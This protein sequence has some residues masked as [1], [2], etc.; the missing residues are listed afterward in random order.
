MAEP[1]LAERW[2]AFV[3][4]LRAQARSNQNYQYFSDGTSPD[5]DT[6][7]ESSRYSAGDQLEETLRRYGLWEDE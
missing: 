1:T 5:Y 4:E 2:K 7:Y 3:D 6:G